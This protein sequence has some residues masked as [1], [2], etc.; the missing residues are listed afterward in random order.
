MIGPGLLATTL[1]GQIALLVFGGLAVWFGAELLVRHSSRLAKRL[2][3]S[4]FIIGATVVAFGTSA[5]E[6]VVS[7]TAQLEGKSGISLGNIIGSNVANIALVLGITAAL[8]PIRVRSRTLYQELPI[9]LAAEFLFFW[10]GSDGTL[11]STDA[12]ILGLA[13]VAI[14]TWMIWTSRSGSSAQS[15]SETAAPSA[16]VK[17]VDRLGRDIRMTIAGLLL[18]VFGAR[19]FVEGAEDF[20]LSMGMSRETVGLT[21]VAIGTSLPELVTSIVAA[22]RGQID[23]SLGNL[24]GS[25]LFNVLFVGGSLSLVGTVEVAPTIQSD[26]WWMIGVTAAIFPLVFWTRL[27]GERGPKRLDRLSGLLLLGSYAYYLYSKLSA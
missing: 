22:V 10:L 26:C 12:L 15:A 27:L 25:N 20:A 4:P 16:E 23:I 21:I 3:F 11:D 14:Y 9:V 17:A 2:G 13:F 18:L 8:M 7:F 19:F 24:L 5:P 6:W 1:T